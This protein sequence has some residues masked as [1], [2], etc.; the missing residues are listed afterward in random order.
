V[1]VPAEEFVMLL[2]IAAVLVVLWALGF[3]AVHIGGALIHIF[4]GL[5]II[6]VILHFARR[7]SAG[8]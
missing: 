7:R 4:V 3:F 8:V 1:I 6:A 2:A 5:A